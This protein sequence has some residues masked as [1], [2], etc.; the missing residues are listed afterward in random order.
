LNEK[1]QALHVAYQTSLSNT[2]KIEQTKRQQ[3]AERRALIQK[4]REAEE[5]VK[6]TQ[7]EITRLKSELP[8]RQLLEQKK[9]AIQKLQ[10]ELLKQKRSEVQDEIQK[11]IGFITEEC[12]GLEELIASSSRK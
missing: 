1:L 5:A 4:T 11:T 7:N 2:R 3:E 12:A 10:T 9:A 8:L 6:R